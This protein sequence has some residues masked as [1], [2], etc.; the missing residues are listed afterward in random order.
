MKIIEVRIISPEGV[1]YE[2]KAER[3]I[4]PGESGVFEVL[5]FHKRLMSRLLSGTVLIDE[6]PIPIYRGVVRVESNA[7]TIIMEKKRK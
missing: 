2:G 3:V 7:V 6:H 1:V 5:P 4:M